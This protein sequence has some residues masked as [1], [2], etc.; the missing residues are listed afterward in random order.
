MNQ[1]IYTTAT[2]PK[3]AFLTDAVTHPGLSGS[4]VISEPPASILQ[5]P[6][7]P[8]SI[9]KAARLMQFDNKM[10]LLGI[11]A[12]ELDQYSDLQLNNAVYPSAIMEM[13]EPQDSQDSFDEFD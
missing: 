3:N 7:A 1:L 2:L 4:P 11:H 8:E 9:Y 13:L 12:G 10:S 6:D 5:N